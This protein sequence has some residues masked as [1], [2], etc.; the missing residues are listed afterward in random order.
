MSNENTQ[1]STNSDFD[2]LNEEPKSNDLV[3]WII[4]I[5]ITCVA[6]YAVPTIIGYFM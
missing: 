4:A 2:D 5:V 3:G 1:N 6:I